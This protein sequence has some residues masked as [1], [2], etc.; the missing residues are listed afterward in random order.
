[1]MRGVWPTRRLVVSGVGDRQ[2]LMGER[3]TAEEHRNGG[4]TTPLPG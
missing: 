3:N 4:K 2:R 1:M